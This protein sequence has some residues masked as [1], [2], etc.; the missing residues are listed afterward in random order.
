MNNWLEI[1][2]SSLADALKKAKDG[3]LPLQ[4]LYMLAPVLY[5]EKQNAKNE[6][7]I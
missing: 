2:K 1:A 6:D 7:L 3:G 5:S 4:N